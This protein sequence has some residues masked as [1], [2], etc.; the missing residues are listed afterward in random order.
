MNVKFVRWSTMLV[1]L[2][3]G[4]LVLAQDQERQPNERRKER[5]ERLQALKVAHITNQL[6][7]TQ[8]E[9]AEFWSIYNKYDQ[10]I[11]EDRQS[12]LKD[13]KPLETLTEREAQL[14][15]NEKYKFE[16]QKLIYKKRMSEELA[17]VVGYKKVALLHKAEK[18]FKKK[19]L[20]RHKK[21]QKARKG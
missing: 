9:S 20:K 3:L 17:A 11:R 18:T 7:L 21:R 15:I 19:V 14:L 6:D 12:I 8:D 16:E 13:I 5:K 1:L 4:T 10:L 2:F